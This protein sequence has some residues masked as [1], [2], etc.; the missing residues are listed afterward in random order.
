MKKLLLLI[1]VLLLTL[2]LV[3][4]NKNVDGGEGEEKP[5]Q[6][7]VWATNDYWGGE[8]GKLVSEMVKKYTE[9][10]GIEIIYQPQ[11]NLKDKMKGA[12]L[13]GETADVVIW[14]R[15]ETISFVEENRLLDLKPYLDADG[16][17]LNEYQ[18]EALSEMKHE[19]GVYGLPLDIDAW[20]YWINKTMVKEANE[21]LRA[22]GKP[23]VSE[24]PKT[25]DEIRETA[26][27]TTKFDQ[28][29]KM[30]VAGMNVDTAGSFFSY[31]QTAGGQMLK[32]N[33]KGEVVA[34]FNTP[35]GH[36]VV[37]FWYDLVHTHKVYEE[38]ILSTLGG[39]DDPFIV[40]K[41][42][43][44]SNSLLNGSK[45]YAQYIGDKFEYEFVPF[46][47][48]PSSDFATGDNPAGTNSGGLMGGFGLTVPKT[49]KN[50]KAAYNLIKWWITDTEKV[51][52][53]A[54]ISQLIPAKI[55]VIEELKN[56]NIP[57]VRNVLD[58][59][60]NLKIRPQVPG[61]P[62]VET[63]VIM[64][65]IPTVIFGDGYIKG[66]PTV[67]DRINALLRDM[68]KQANETFAYARM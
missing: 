20:G 30:T 59:L 43:I 1:T 28:N 6:L 40:G 62:A 19:N 49:S 2:F 15:W 13:G 65:K 11:P 45:F 61:Y 55:S 7:V 8:N 67:E 25:W 50:Q 3:S 47:K 39:A 16:I 31:I 26:I 10:T 35:E 60:P 37:K 54:R 33:D 44:Q 52:E 38:G 4:C 66:N 42:A 12:F 29:G 68:E 46:P 14:D 58:V 9:E 57:N 51:I 64:A 48:G 27:A 23:E 41:V 32:T 36:A 56:E 24:L 34:G 17:D 53:W 18:Q 63:G 5:D 21:Q 22:A